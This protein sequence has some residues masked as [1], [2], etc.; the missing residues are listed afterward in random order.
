MNSTRTHNRKRDGLVLKGLPGDNP[1]GFLAALG[2]LR[3]LSRSWPH[4]GITMG[5]D[6]QEGWRPVLGED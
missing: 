4:R 6:P 3:V 5:W 1:L 2:V